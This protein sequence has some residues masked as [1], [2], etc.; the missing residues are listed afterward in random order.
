METLRIPSLGESKASRLQ[1]ATGQVALQRDRARSIDVFSA[2]SFS[3]Q[4][5]SFEMDVENSL[6]SHE[7]WGPGPNADTPATGD[8]VQDMDVL[9]RRSSASGVGVE[10]RALLAEHPDSDNLACILHLKGQEHQRRPNPHYISSVQTDVNE[11]MRAILMDWLAEV[12]QEWSL[13]GDT[14]FLAVNLVD[15][16]LSVRA[17]PRTDLQLVGAACLWV[18]CKYE[19]LSPPTASD[20]VYITDDTYTK[21]QVVV[22]EAVILG[23]LGF[24]V[25]VPTVKA[26]LRCLL[27]GCGANKNLHYLSNYL[28]E[29]SLLDHTMMRYL[30]SEIAAA[31]VYLANLMLGKHQPWDN[32]LQHFATYNATQLASCVQ[33]L[34]A[35]H[36]AMSVCPT[37]VSIRTKYAA[38]RC[39][40]VSLLHPL[41]HLHVTPDQGVMVCDRHYMEL[42]RQHSSTGSCCSSQTQA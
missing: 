19:E 42:P 35:L 40:A 5:I 6:P 17:V 3:D 9:S 22:M 10:A 26:F 41:Q 23:T 21:E 20:F 37:L 31:A 38:P 29:L 12:A 2:P 18:A 8:A 4:Q 1:A 27:K 16:F 28:A 36:H 15:R 33:A 14:L 25:T 7:G 13:C 39:R 30:P 11:K 24:E 34:A 32:T